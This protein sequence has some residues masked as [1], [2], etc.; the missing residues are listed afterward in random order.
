[1]LSFERFARAAGVLAPA[2]PDVAVAHSPTGMTEGRR[3]RVLAPLLA[4]TELREGFQVSVHGCPKLLLRELQLVFPGQFR[5]RP[6]EGQVLAVLTCQRS[7]MD[8]SQFGVDADREKDR[9]LETFVAFAQHV[10]AALI[11]RGHWADFIDPC[12]GLPV[13]HCGDCWPCGRRRRRRR[14]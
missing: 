4:P 7:L 12:S 11:A 14:D 3:A 6:A 2:R 5:R 9:L 8:L 13:R 10:T 1:M